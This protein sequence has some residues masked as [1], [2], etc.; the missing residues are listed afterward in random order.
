MYPMERTAQIEDLFRRQAA[1]LERVVARQVRA[2]ATVIEDACAFAWMQL[3]AHEAVD[4]SHEHAFA[5][6]A[7][8]AVRQA[9]RL[10]AIE[11]A[12]IARLDADDAIDPA[13]AM[14]VEDHVAA[15]EALRL[16]DELTPKQAEMMRL[17]AAGLSYHEIADALDVTYTNVNKHLTKA[18]AKL[19]KLRAEGAE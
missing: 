5:W 19:R 3:V 8:V 12:D 18:R 15:R 16:L 2:D 14:N 11:N 10:A 4:P 9:W 7:R 1:R 6:L 13:S 17:F